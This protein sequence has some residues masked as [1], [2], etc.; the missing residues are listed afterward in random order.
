KNGLPDMVHV[1]IP[2]KA[3]LMGLWMKRTYQTQFILSEHWGM[4]EL[5]IRGNFFE[6][7]KL[8]RHLIAG[9]YLQAG[10][11]VSVSRFLSAGVETAL[12]RKTDMIIP[13]VVDT[14]LFY[15]KAEKYSVFSFIHVSNLHP[16][17]NAGGIL[18]AYARHRETEH[19]KHS[20]LVFV[21]NRDETYV[22]QSVQMG[23]LNQS[24]FF[25]GEV[26]Y[27]EVAREVG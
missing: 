19:G 14:S 27:T 17:K 2:W 13:N 20:Q 9:I 3:G 11:F 4:Y 21:G 1:H 8:E 24:V 10:A 18:E 26:S 22:K 15:P 7:S 16:V 5:G 12:G 25:R 6:R 23:L